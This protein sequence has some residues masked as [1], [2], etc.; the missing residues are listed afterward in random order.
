MTSVPERAVLHC[1]PRPSESQH[2][3]TAA[4][5]R[6]RAW[7]RL[8]ACL[9]LASMLA[10]EASQ[11]AVYAQNADTGGVCEGVEGFARLPMT[12][13][14][15]PQS[16]KTWNI[17]LYAAADFL[18]GQGFNPL[19]PFANFVGS[20]SHTNVLVLEDRYSWTENDVV[21]SVEHQTC[22]VRIT[23]V[24]DLGE[25]ETD[26]PG[27]LE[28]FLRFAQE[29]FPAER[30]LLFMYGHG[31]A[32]RGACNDESN[33]QSNWSFDLENWLTPVEMRT[34]LEA[35]GGVDALMFSAPCTMS[36]L[37]AAYELRDVTKLY[38]ASEEI[39]GYLYWWSA[40][41]RIATSL[42]T[43]PDQSLRAFGEATIN[44]IRETMQE[45]LD[46]G[47]WSHLVTRLPNIAAVRTSSLGDLATAVNLFAES[48]LS[49][50]PQMR[51]DILDARI[52]VPQFGM[53]ELVD[54]YAFAETCQS[55]PHLSEVAGAVMQGVDG[56]I[57][58]QVAPGA[59]PYGNAGGLSLYFPTP[60]SNPSFEGA[61]EAYLNYG[62]SFLTD[63]HWDEA[64]EAL[65]WSQTNP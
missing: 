53:G 5:S 44:A 65:L 30:T 18:Q 11:V 38:V 45:A 8:V 60:V 61:G 43:D 9:L 35:V 33:G 19:E 41:G 2:L 17:L 6:P 37:E 62:L 47:Y 4:A 16:T 27:T 48:T 12:V 51:E 39:S 54:V 26:E 57:V 10:I 40:V 21:W 42:E 23:P 29:W 31:A 50:L 24:L 20:S 55:I 59:S 34:A 28:Q 52:H 46:A 13:P 32:W 56:A 63:T 58:A 25:A 1:A 49:H 36:S 64:L 15:A 7:L 22:S 14:N 3:C